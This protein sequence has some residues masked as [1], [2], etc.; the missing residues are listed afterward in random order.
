MSYGGTPAMFNLD[1][2]FYSLK[3]D[4]EGVLTLWENFAGEYNNF[5]GVYK[6]FDITFISNANATY[7]KIFDTLEYR[8]DVYD[9]SNNLLHDK[10]FT[11]I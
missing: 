4:K 2:K 11:T 7:N 9:S 5:Y 1:S 3:K 6:P 8:A 10:S